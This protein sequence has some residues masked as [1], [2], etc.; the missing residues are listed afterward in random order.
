[1]SKKVEEQNLENRGKKEK[2]V[3]ER[4]EELSLLGLDD[5]LFHLL[6]ILPIF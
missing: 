5:T 1:M 4:K 3:I 6:I 2:R